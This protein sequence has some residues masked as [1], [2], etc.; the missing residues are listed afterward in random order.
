MSWDESWKPA[1]TCPECGTALTGRFCANCGQKQLDHRLNFY[2]LLCDLISRVTSV[3]RGLFF[4]FWQLC[5][6]PGIVARDY[7]HGCQ[8]RFT[9]PLTYFFLS[10]AAQ[11]AAI[12]LLEEPMRQGLTQQFN[13]QQNPQAVEKL[14]EIFG[15]QAVEIIVD[16]YFNAIQQAYLYCALLFFCLPFSLIVLGGQRIL[17][18]R[19]TW[20]ETVVFSLF[21]SGHCLM[22]TAILAL[23]TAQIDMSWQFIFN[24]LFV[25]ILPQQAHTHFFPEGWLSRSLTLIATLICSALLLLSIVGVFAASV[26]W[27]VVTR[28]P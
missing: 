26:A 3:E 12:W 4:T 17:G 23:V 11:M 18:K 7:V 27:A 21:V 10:V 19:F 24:A 2:E 15:G 16:S 6:R 9:N 20:G 22:T 8:K 13:P 25:L 14:N 28:I 5:R 1:E